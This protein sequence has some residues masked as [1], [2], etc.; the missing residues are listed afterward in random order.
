V[1]TLSRTAGTVIRIP[2]QKKRAPSN[3]DED[4]DPADVTVRRWVDPEREEVERR[5]PWEP[6]RVARLPPRASRFDRSRR[7]NVSDSRW[8][9]DP[10]RARRVVREGLNALSADPSLIKNQIGE[11]SVLSA[12]EERDL[13]TFQS[14]IEAYGL[15]KSP[16][17]PLC[18]G[19]FGPPG[20]GKSFTV[21]QVL[22]HTGHALRIINLSQLEGP[23]D[24]SSALAE[25]ARWST[26]NTPAVFFDEFDC[27]LEGTRL[28]WLQWLLA[29]M[30]DGVVVDRGHPIEMKRAVFVF[31]GGM[32]DTFEDF[33]A[34]HGDYFRTAKGPDFASRLRGHVNVLG[35]N[36]WPYRRVRRATILRLSIEKVA[37][38][39]LDVGRIPE[40][41][42]S[43]GFIDQILSVG[44]STAHDRSRRWWRCRQG[45]TL[46]NFRELTHT[47]RKYSIAIST[48][49]P[50][51]A[52][53]SR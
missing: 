37:P 31:A 6:P 53:P 27:A 12:D 47:L 2:R 44:L 39:L 45:R 17:H 32:A 30:Q 22:A 36:N 23:G 48:R 49:V 4:I 38:G 18:L 40:E 35:V 15:L 11:L 50:W 3:R 14:R 24:L 26:G 19:V 8:Q 33:P 34:A 16:K 9:D 7:A 1:L 52:W 51:A 28:G 13:A 41:R 21:Q 5:V 29:P 10:V 46:R 20:S 42:M 43:D 25:V